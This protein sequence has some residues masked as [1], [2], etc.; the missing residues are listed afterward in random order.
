MSKTTTWAFCQTSSSRKLFSTPLSPSRVAGREPRIAASYRR[1]HL[2]RA[3]HDFLD[4]AAHVEGLLGDLVQLALDQHLEAFD[5]VFDFYVAALEAGEDRK[6]T[7]LNS[8]HS[9]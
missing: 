9:S 8:S 7:R 6:S 3:L 2:F 1:L 5:G 4:R